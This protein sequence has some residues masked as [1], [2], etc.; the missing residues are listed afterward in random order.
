MI[1]TKARVSRAVGVYRSRRFRRRGI[2]FRLHGGQKSSIKKALKAN[3]QLLATSFDSNERISEVVRL[4]AF[5]GTF[6]E[7][8]P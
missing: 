7:Y 5:G 8:F 1:L 6:T 3:L 4:L 2:K